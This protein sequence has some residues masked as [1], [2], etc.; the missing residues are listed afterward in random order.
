MTLG[1]HPRGLTTSGNAQ[2]SKSAWRPIQGSANEKT[3]SNLPTAR[4]PERKSS[5][6]SLVRKSSQITQGSFDVDVLPHVKGPR[7]DAFIP[8]R[9]RSHSPVRLAAERLDHVSSDK[10]RMHARTFVRSVKPTD[11]LDA[12]DLPHA[13]VSIHTQVSA[14]LFVGGSAVEGEASVTFDGGKPKYHFTKLPPISIG[15]LSV[16]MLGVEI[17]QGRK[18]IFRCLATELIDEDYPPP[19]TMK[20][21]ARGISEAYWRVAPSTSV[22]PFRLELPINMG[23]PPYSSRNASI[24][25]IL[26]TTLAMMINEKHYHVRRS[27]E[28]AILTIHDRELVTHASHTLCITLASRYETGLT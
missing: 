12:C 4:V 1:S 13:R 5:R 22:I 28:L 18:H 7:I 14:P 16:D 15:R 9:G 19:S 8:P 3:T 17:A 21:A 25:Y 2:I 6:R 20:V 27:Q 24:K 23:P 10:L 11:I 26:C